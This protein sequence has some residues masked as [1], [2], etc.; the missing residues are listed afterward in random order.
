MKRKLIAVF[1]VCAILITLT[2]CAPQ[3]SEDTLTIMGKDI[4][5][6]AGYMQ[7]IFNHYEKATGKKLKIISIK[8]DDFEAR[9]AKE[10]KKGNVPD[11]FMCFNNTDLNSFF[12]VEDNFY[13]L[14]DESWASD[15]T[16]S[17][18]EACVNKDGNLLGLPFW[19][20]SL[21]GCY[22]NKTILDKLGLKPAT[23]QAEFDALCRAL[24]SV[25]YTPICWPGECGWMYQ[26]GLDP[27]FADNPELLEKLNKNEIDYA[28]IPEVREM[29]QWIY[30]ASQKGWFGNS[31]T[32][33]GWEDIASVLGSGKAVMTF[34]WDSW[35]YSRF[36]DSASV[37]KK[38]DFALMPIFMNTSNS[39]MYEDGNLSMLMVSKNS[40]KRGEA[41]DFLNFCATQENYNIAFDGVSTQNVFKGQT[42]NIQSTMVT[43][44]AASVNTYR[45]PSIAVNKII[46]YKQHDMIEVFKKLFDGSTDVDGCV[47]LMDE[48]RKTTAQNLGA[49]G[50]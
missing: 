10:F 32:D 25:G 5:I 29:A 28:D 31:Y 47:E 3:N 20:N 16:D 33:C 41:L 17:A 26:F 18:F 46:G 21:S 7:R 37:Y 23:T 42:T 11:I 15:L 22:Y 35:F 6:S 39:G 13:Y 9:A 27:I 30:D 36:D 14:N 49:A 44:N 48:Y 4:D 45:R 34:I 24:L 19:E 50:F 2:S 40:E 8:D 38:D 12:D 43:D 1:T